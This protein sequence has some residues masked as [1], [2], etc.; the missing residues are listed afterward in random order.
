MKQN[1][2]DFL[3]KTASISAITTLA[4][5]I[6]ISQDL[7]D[8]PATPE[9]GH[10]FLTKP[11][12]QNPSVNSITVMW[13]V[14]LPSYSYVEYGETEDLGRIA[15]SVDSGLVVA[16]NR[17]NSITLPNLE[18]GTKY[19]YRV[20][21][22][23]ITKFHPYKIE[24]GEKIA[25]EVYSFSTL[26]S[27]QEEVSML[28]FNDIHD[29]PATIPHLMNLVDKKSTDFVFFNGD[30]LGHIDIE[31]QVITH[32]LRTCSEEFATQTP[33]YFVRGNHETRGKFAR[34]LHQY[35]SNPNG[36]QYYDFIW[37]STHFTVIDSGEDKSDDSEV[38]AGIV[39]FD[40]YRAEQANWFKN[41]VSKSVEFQQAKFRVVL[42]HIPIYYSGDWHGTMHLREL[43]SDLFNQ[44]EIDVCISGHT[45]KYG[46]YEPT[47]GEHN[48]PII[49]GGGPKKGNRTVI[50]LKADSNNLSISILR[51]DGVEVGSYKLLSE[52]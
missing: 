16:Y 13:I 10:I 33:F 51:D 25:S 36:K 7:F 17:I 14:N 41:E 24:Y 22:K 35:F 18:P 8:R 49:I 5:T 11:Y 42:M 50:N 38:Y 44:A 23:E 21:S 15:R 6:A 3:R 26:S 20:V 34:N 29:R 47:K 37:G 48:Y 4:P 40:N 12:L 9:A 27:K 19:F 32:L 2:R 52:Y 31:E 1:R 39:D 46:V 28:I 43:F 30:I 45:H